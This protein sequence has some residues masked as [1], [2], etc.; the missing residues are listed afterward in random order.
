MALLFA[1]ALLCETAFAENLEHRPSARPRTTALK[2]AALPLNLRQ[3][4]T[5]NPQALFYMTRDPNSVRSFLAHAD[6]V[7][8]L[9]PAW[10]T[11][12]A[13]G[14][15]SG[16]PNPLVMQ[17]AREHHVPVMPIVA[18]AGFV[19]AEVHKLLTDPNAQGAMI[20]ELIAACKENGY[21]GFQFDFE[22]VNWTDQ[23]AFS[24]MMGAAADALHKQNL[25]ISVATVP[26]AP[27]RAGETG[28]DAW[29][30][31][32]W[33]GVY[34]LKTLARSAD[35]ICLMTYDQ[36]TR[37]TAPGPVAGWDW[38]VENVDYALK[39]V[40]AN[41][42]YVGI[43]LYGYHWFAGTPARITPANPIEKPNPSAEYI[44]TPD[45]LDL[46]RAYGGHIEWDPRDR[47]AWFYFYRD[48]MREWIF[49]T[50]ARTFRERYDLAKRRGLGGFC[51]WVLGTEDAGIWDV[52][53]AHR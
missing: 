11:V 14:L 35:F 10:Y 39:F 52:L 5:Q 32:N 29:L 33:Q 17:T 22:D 50:D 27:G 25:E 40:P 44:S 8:I 21:T 26:N 41:K 1:C 19:Q 47:T 3:T 24:A 46:A 48:N 51:S 9:V 4:S 34:D 7:D 16:G 20:S 15:V 6:R 13:T 36:H 23:Q 31:E 42:L 43:P 18:G 49:Y 28:F 30:Y 37:W 45:A 38:T 53:P 2:S 12:D